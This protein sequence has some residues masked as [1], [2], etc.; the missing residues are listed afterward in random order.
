MF[1]GFFRTFSG[2]L[3]LLFVV[4]AVFMG[5][6]GSLPSILT[7]LLVISVAMNV[8]HFKPKKQSVHW[9]LM[10]EMKNVRELT[11]LRHSFQ[12]VVQ[13]KTAKPLATP[14]GEIMLPGTG[15]SFIL[16]YSGTT[17]CGCDLSK[18]EVSERFAVN[19]VRFTVPHSKILD[20]VPDMKSAEIYDEK[21]G[22]FARSAIASD[23]IEE[24]NKDLEKQRLKLMESDILGHADEQVRIVLTS[25]AAS[26]NMEAE[27]IFDD[28]VH[29]ANKNVPVLLVKTDTPNC[30][31]KPVE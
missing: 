6:F 10:Q 8:W 3:A 5:P 15:R 25:L 23:L 31:L 4:M 22:I 16:T 11:T 27:V 13:H 2:I 20:I 28:G 26:V 29:E 12:S 30:V 14:L 18:I 7:L 17:T 21:V 19:R 24:I 9:M 1:S